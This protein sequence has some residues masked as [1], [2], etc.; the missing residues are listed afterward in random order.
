MAN[1]KMITL[2]LGESSKLY[3][4]DGMTQLFVCEK[5]NNPSEGWS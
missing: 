3:Q 5:Y 1:I 2:V 4:Y